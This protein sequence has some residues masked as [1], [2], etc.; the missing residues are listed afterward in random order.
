M[1]VMFLQPK[2]ATLNCPVRNYNERNLTLQRNILIEVKLK[3]SYWVGEE[4]GVIKNG[5]CPVRGT[6]KTVST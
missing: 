6:M 4:I 3:G 2:I 5:P 1:Y